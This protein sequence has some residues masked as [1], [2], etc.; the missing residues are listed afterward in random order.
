M[1]RY[2]SIIFMLFLLVGCSNNEVKEIN[3]KNKIISPKIEDENEIICALYKSEGE[4]RV[5]A[6]EI[7]EEWIVN[8]DITVLTMIPTIEEILPK[9]NI[10]EEFYKYFNSYKNSSN[11]KIGY[12]IS[13]EIDNERNFSQTILKP[14]D[15]ASFYDYVQ[16]YLYDD[17]NNAG[18]SF[19]SHVEKMEDNTLL[20]S[21]KLTGST[22]IN[23]IT[24]PIEL[25]S[26]TYKDEKDFN[27]NNKYIG[28]SM[29]KVIIN[30]R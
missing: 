10:K 15:T 6:K 30:N 5:L 28:K 20:T 9:E 1:K 17:I 27:K 14:E 25:T 19:Y 21:I 16:V 4:K 22:Y 13:F 11:Y 26:F 18:K 3:T 23:N 7:N 8:K 24:S 29:Y 12:Q 2:L